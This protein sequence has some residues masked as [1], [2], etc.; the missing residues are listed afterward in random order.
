MLEGRPALG[1]LD[2]LRQRTVAGL[3]RRLIDVLLSRR[4]IQTEP[5]L[6]HAR[7]FFEDYMPPDDL[8]RIPR[9]PRISARTIGPC[10]TTTVTCCWIS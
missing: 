7:L 8:W 2:L 6:A 9:W 4:W 1:N 10:G 5:V 3:T